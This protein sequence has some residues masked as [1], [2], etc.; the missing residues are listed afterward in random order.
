MNGIIR[1]AIPGRLC[2]D[3]RDIRLWLPKNSIR[4]DDG[5]PSLALERAMLTFH[6]QAPADSAI[7][8][9]VTGKTQAEN[10]VFR[11]QVFVPSGRSF[12][13]GPRFTRPD[14]VRFFGMIGVFFGLFGTTPIFR[15]AAK[16]PDFAAESSTFPVS[17]SEFRGRFNFPRL[18]QNSLGNSGLFPKIPKGVRLGIRF[19]R[20]PL[21][22]PRSLDEPR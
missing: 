10:L 16:T 18:H 2:A 13:P 1:L 11:Q 17:E 6:S 5:S 14:R 20:Q 3:R 19:F 8:P 22:F 21:P 7:P 15:K 4:R 9:G 12:C